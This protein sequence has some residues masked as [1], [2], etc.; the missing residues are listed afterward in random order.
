MLNKIYKKSL[1]K[2]TQIVFYPLL[3]LLDKKKLLNLLANFRFGFLHEPFSIAN[4]K[5]SS[6]HKTKKLLKFLYFQWMFHDFFCYSSSPKN[7]SHSSALY[8]SRT[9]N[10]FPC[11]FPKDRQNCL[12]LLFILIILKIQFQSWFASTR[13]SKHKYQNML[14]CHFLVNFAAEQT[15]NLNRAKFNKVWKFS[16]PFFFVATAAENSKLFQK[17]RELFARKAELGAKSLLFDWMRI[18]WT[19]LHALVSGIKYGNL[20]W[21]LCELLFGWGKVEIKWK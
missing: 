13:F 14:F 10:F 8:Y 18:D 7:S 15:N 3:L 21:I 9:I 5:I 6:Q 19:V 1:N 16:I 2:T 11:C 4:K 12:I 20:N 17:S